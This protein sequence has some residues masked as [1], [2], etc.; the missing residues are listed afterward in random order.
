[1]HPRKPDGKPDYSKS[2]PCKCR[3][4][5]I[6]ARRNDRLL[7]L[8]NLPFVTGSWTLDNYETD[9]RWPSL[10]EAKQAAIDYAGNT[11]DAEWLILMGKRDTGKTHLAIGICRRWLTRGKAAKYILVPQMLDD[12][13]EGYGQDRRREV[14]YR[15]AQEAGLS[16]DW[17]ELPYEAQMRMLKDVDL[18]VLDDLGAQVPTPWAMEKIMMIID[19]RYINGLSL[20]VT[21]NK[22]LNKLPGDAEGRIGSRLLRFQASKIITLDSDEYRTWRRKDKQND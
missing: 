1:M 2:L 6:L 14:S 5:E 13:R 18:L 9:K 12:L 22:P 20:V 17:G 21:T 3:E 4:A 8:C 19:Y 11:G 16:G 7:E 15:R 10:A